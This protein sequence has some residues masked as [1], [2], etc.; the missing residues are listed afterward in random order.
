M[1]NDWRLVETYSYLD[2]LDLTA[3]AWE[4]LRRNSDYRANYKSLASEGNE[5]LLGRRW[6]CAANPNLSA[7]QVSVV[8]LSAPSAMRRVAETIRRTAVAKPARR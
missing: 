1:Q 6:G 3:F 5:A 2:G 4:F 8:W 7:D